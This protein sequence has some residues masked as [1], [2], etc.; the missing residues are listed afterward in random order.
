MPLSLEE[1]NDGCNE[2]TDTNKS[3]RRTGVSHYYDKERI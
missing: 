3:N 1:V 2:K